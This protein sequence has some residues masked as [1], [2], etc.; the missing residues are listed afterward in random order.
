MTTP[1]K[2]ETP[3][4]KQ[5]GWEV[6][7]IP[8]M[9]QWDKPGT[10]ISGKLLSLVMVTIK[11]NTKPVPQYM[12]ATGIKNPARIKFLG[13][14]DLT[15]RLGSEHV[16]M[17]VRVKYLGEDQTVKRGDNFM[18]VFDVHVRPDPNAAPQRDSGPITD[19]D[20]PF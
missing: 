13:T 16:G 14:Y 12:L 8:E 9:Q 4:E 11:G 17:M 5:D 1:T 6:I 20:I 2:L 19:E 18:K 15:Q 10:T 3:M 7:Q